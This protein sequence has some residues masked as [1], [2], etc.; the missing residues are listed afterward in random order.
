MMVQIVQT[1]WAD[2]Y[3]LGCDARS[4]AA[5]VTTDESKVPQ[6]ADGN[7]SPSMRA[8]TPTKLDSFARCRAPHHGPQSRRRSSFSGHEK[9]RAPSLPSFEA[10]CAF[11]ARTRSLSLRLVS[12]RGAL[13]LPSPFPLGA[14]LRLVPSFAVK[15]GIWKYQSFPP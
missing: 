4:V 1:R 3:P 2:Y 10:V 12:P 7:R 15:S 8:R 13:P 6:V 5:G 11:S 14:R 9:Q